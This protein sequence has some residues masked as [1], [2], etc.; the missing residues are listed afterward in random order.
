[1]HGGGL[2]VRMDRGVKEPAHVL[3]R[4][5]A[6]S[7]RAVCGIQGRE[8]GGAGHLCGRRAGSNNCAARAVRAQVPGLR[9]HGRAPGLHRNPPARA[10]HLWRL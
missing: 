4:P 5:H 6:P 1:M 2:F 8:C 3:Q 7:Q 9:G 10:V